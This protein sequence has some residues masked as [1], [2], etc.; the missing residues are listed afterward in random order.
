M[1]LLSN[2]YDYDYDAQTIDR[3]AK[4]EIVTSDKQSAGLQKA[5]LF[6]E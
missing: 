3:I 4:V 6:Y 2:D 5:W 1:G